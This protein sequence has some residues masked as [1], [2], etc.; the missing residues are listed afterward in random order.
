M[1]RGRKLVSLVVVERSLNFT[2]SQNKEYYT[3]YAS[4]FKKIELIKIR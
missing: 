1:R 3:V 2:Y 4:P